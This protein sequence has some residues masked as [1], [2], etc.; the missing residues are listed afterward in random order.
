MSEPRRAESAPSRAGPR[1]CRWRSG[2]ASASARW[3]WSQPADLPADLSADHRGRGGG[4]DLGAAAARWPAPGASG[5]AGFRSPSGRSPPSA[6]LAVRPVSRRASGVAAT[7][8]ACMVWRFRRGAAGYLADVAASIFVLVYLGLFASFATL[9]LVPADGAYRIITFLIMV[10]CSRRR[11]LRRRRAVRP[12]PDGAG[13]LAEEVLG[14]LRRLRRCWP[15]SA[16]RCRVWLM[17]DGRG[18]TALI[19]GVADRRRRH[20]R[21]PRRVA[22]QARPRREG[23]GHAAA[24]SRRGDGPDGLAAAVRGGDLGG[25]SACWCPCPKVSTK[26]IGPLRIRS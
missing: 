24:R 16:A 22:D 14:G 12:A 4:V 20:R 8:L 23:H 11:R 25:R 19:V 6:C 9:L 13:D 17:L 2:S 1:T 7:A 5:S 26:P 15:R 10:V 21:R 18:G 3:C